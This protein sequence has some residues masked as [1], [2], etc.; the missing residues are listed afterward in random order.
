ML[1]DACHRIC[2]CV[3]RCGDVDEPEDGPAPWPVCKGL[4]RPPRDNY[5]LRVVLVDRRTREIV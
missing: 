3:S 2:A 4:P 1:L 5:G